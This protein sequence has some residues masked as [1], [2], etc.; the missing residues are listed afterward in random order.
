MQDGGDARAGTLIAKIR[1]KVRP[2]GKPIRGLARIGGKSNDRQEP[3]MKIARHLAVPPVAWAAWAAFASATA[4]QP[5]VAQELA[6]PELEGLVTDKRVYLA[7]PFGGEFPLH[8]R[9]DG[10][11]TGDGSALGLG[12]FFAPRETGN[13]WVDGTSLCQQFP[14]W[15]NGQTSCFAIEQTGAQTINWRRNDGETGTARIEG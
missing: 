2:A 6:G 10:S 15:Y 3:T 14:T 13:W 12:R 5:A 7:T 9:S 11:V 1:Q 8:Y 4:V